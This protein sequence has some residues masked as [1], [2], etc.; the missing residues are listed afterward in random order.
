MENA[1]SAHKVPP[2]QLQENSDPI[3]D[4]VVAHMKEHGVERW[5]DPQNSLLW[6]EP[7]TDIMSRV[8]HVVKAGLY[9]RDKVSFRIKSSTVEKEEGTQEE[10][11]KQEEGEGQAKQGEGEGQAKQGEGEGQEEQGEEQEEGGQGEGEGEEEGQD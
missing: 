1:S 3:P 5:Y 4:S 6:V 2:L 8:A 11:Q 10:E 7:T 9:R